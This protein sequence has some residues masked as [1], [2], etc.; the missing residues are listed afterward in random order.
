MI[1][2][3]VTVMTSSN[4][5]MEVGC[6]AGTD[7]KCVKSGMMIAWWCLTPLPSVSTSP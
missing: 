1:K 7:A 5:Q 4:E 3:T 6:K 2:Q